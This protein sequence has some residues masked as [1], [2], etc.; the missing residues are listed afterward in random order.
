MS[1][2]ADG[3]EVRVEPWPAGGWVVRLDG[4]PVPISRHDTE[5]EADARAE[6]YRRGLAREAPLS[7]QDEAT[8]PA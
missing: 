6:A 7:A 8:K 5:D 2:R 4:H 1:A 3:P